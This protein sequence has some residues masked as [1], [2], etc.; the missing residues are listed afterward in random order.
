MAAVYFA[1]SKNGT[2]TFLDPAKYGR[3][4]LE[5][6]SFIASSVFSKKE[7]RG[8]GFV[9][10]LSGSTAEFINIWLIMCAGKMPFYLNKDNKL[11]AELKPILP[12]W[13]FT[14]KKTEGLERGTFSFKFLDKTLVV[15]HNKKR[16][17]TFGKNGVKI[18]QIQINPV[19]GKSVVLKT[20]YLPEPFSHQ[21]RQGDIKRLDIILG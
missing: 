18:K 14:E 7:Q 1:G 5:N 20:P 6:S 3:S 2:K 10:R 13:L 9:A 11:C 4:I 21:L 16:R 15:Y 8:N 17:N 19:K 12:G